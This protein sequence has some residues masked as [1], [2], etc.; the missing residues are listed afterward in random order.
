MSGANPCARAARAGRRAVGAASPT[1]TRICR[2]LPVYLALYL[3]RT[4]SVRLQA[5]RVSASSCVEL[6]RQLGGQA[7]GG[8]S[9]A[10]FIAPVLL[11]SLVTS[12]FGF[13][14][15]PEAPMVVAG[16]LVSDLSVNCQVFSRKRYV[17]RA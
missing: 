8:A 3:H 1:Y 5:S 2:T 16:S 11:L 14:V 13:S 17:L 6:M 7:T 15:G 9:P 10:H 12:T 4:P